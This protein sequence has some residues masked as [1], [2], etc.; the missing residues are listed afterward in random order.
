[1]PLGLHAQRQHKNTHVISLSQKVDGVVEGES[2]VIV[3]RA[4]KLM[5][6]EDLIRELGVDSRGC[7]LEVEEAVVVEEL[8][9]GPIRESRRGCGSLR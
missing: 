5:P 2:V 4:L 9:D 8:I 1:M 6:L 3:P 7:N